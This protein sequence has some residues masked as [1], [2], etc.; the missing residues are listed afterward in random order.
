MASGQPVARRHGEGLTDAA[1]DRVRAAAEQHVGDTRI[2]GLVALVA[3]GDD[4]HV[5][6]LGSARGRRRTRSGATR[7]SG[8]PRRRKPITAAATLAVIEEGLIGL[9]EPV[10]RLLPE[11]A[12]RR[13]LTR[14]DGPLDETVPAERAITTRDLLTFTFGFG[15]LTEMFMVGARRG[16]WSR[17]NASSTCRRSVRPTR[18]CSPTPTPGSRASGRCRCSPSRVSGG[19]T[20]PA[21]RCSA[22]SSRAPP[23]S[24]SPRCCGRGCSSRSGCATPRSGRPRPTG[25]RPRYVG[26]AGRARRCGTSRRA[27]GARRRR[28]GTAPAGSSSTADDLL[29]F[30]RML[31]AGGAPCCRRRRCGR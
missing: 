19:C 13:V 14:M 27:C 28:S 5:E 6:A 3:S 2:P 16:R 22:C 10:D 31:L 29:A 26:E 18:P 4:V 23:G 8:S 9:D 1:R 15:M 11:L 12:G 25:S 24:R 17:P 7:C 30:S 21:R 20:T